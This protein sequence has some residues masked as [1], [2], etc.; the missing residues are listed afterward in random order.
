MIRLNLLPLRLIPK[1]NFG[2]C[3]LLGCLA[4]I[5]SV[6]F[7][8]CQDED[9]VDM[10]PPHDP[11]KSIVCQSFSPLDGGRATQVTLIGSNLGND[12]AALKVY[13]SGI[14]APVVGCA[15][16]R[17]LVWV[18]RIPIVGT[19]E[20]CDITVVIGSKSA[21]FTQKFTYT[22]RA[23][24]TTICGNPNSGDQPFLE[25]PFAEC[26]LRNPSYLIC[27]DQGNLFLSHQDNPNCVAMISQEE[28]YVRKL[29]DC[30]NK[31]NAPS[32]DIS[33]RIIVV[34]AD[35]NSPDRWNETFWEFDPDAGWF[36]KER[37][38][39]KPTPEEIE[40]KQKIDF[41]LQAYKHSFA[42]CELDSMVYYRSNQTGPVL[43][44]NPKTRVAER[45]VTLDGRVDENGYRIPLNLIA[46]APNPNGDGY[47][48][49][50][51]FNPEML[52][53]VLGGGAGGNHCVIRVNVVTGEESLFAGGFGNENAGW[54]D[55]PAATAKFSTPRQL[56]LDDF[57]NFII[58]DNGNHCIRKI[59]IKTGIVSTV[60][61][62][63]GK[64]GYQDGNPDNA[65]FRNPWGLC[66]D[67]RDGSIYIADRGNHCIRKLTIE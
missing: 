3:V 7:S 62:I 33:G 25:G 46:G 43:K 22:P 63:P 42:I 27:D 64:A 5:A 36:G 10:G 6:I 61:G 8:T 49:F 13:F 18:P 67:R 15:N 30:G 32:T 65:L 60:V 37:R 59:D 38:C 16:G 28:G 40:S 41:V 11:N 35:G 9:I 19:E 23:V 50:D 47:L 58:A 17:V 56:V 39:T 45:A 4:V 53:C 34:P 52:Y 44:F 31:P 26:V 29:M 51:P 57:G 20:E 21:S 1:I 54:K 24:V 14:E 66:I 55:G 12:P 48:M 2:N